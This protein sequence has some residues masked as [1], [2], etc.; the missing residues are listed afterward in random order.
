MGKYKERRNFLTSYENAEHGKYNERHKFPNGYLKNI[1]KEGNVN[2][3][4]K[5]L[6]CIIFQRHFTCPLN[7]ICING[8]VA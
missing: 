2:C 8:T 3:T 1:L 6:C 7:E 4:L 5:I